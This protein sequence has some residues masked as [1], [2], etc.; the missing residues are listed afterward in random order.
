MTGK[1]LGRLLVGLLTLVLAVGFFNGAKSAPIVA[2]AA[3]VKGYGTPTQDP[4]S[5]LFWYSNTGF[6]TQP[7]DTYT[8]VGTTKKLT[9]AVGYSFLDTFFNPLAYDHFQ[10][11]QSMDAGATWTAIKG[12]TSSTLSVTPSK[13]G[14]TYYQESFGYYLFIPP[15]LP[16]EY[17]YS[18]VASVTAMGSPVNATGITVT[19]DN[20]YLYSNQSEAGTTT[21]HANLIP[22]NATS[23]VTWSSS[24]PGLATVD[25]TSGVV[26][27]NTSGR[28]G[29]AT[30]NGTVTN[31]DG[32]TQTNSTQIKVGGGLDDQTVDSGKSATFTVQGTFPSTPASVTW[33]KEAPGSSTPTK[34]ASGTSLTY[35]TPTTSAADDKAHYY[36]EITIKSDS[37]SKT[38]TT[39]AAELNV[40]FSDTPKVTITSTATDNTDNTGNVAHGLSNVISGDAITITG[41]ITDGNQDSKM[42]AG[43]L[44]IRVPPY[45]SNTAV[46]IDGEATSL[47]APKQIGDYYYLVPRTPV[48]F[49]AG[50]TH[51]YKVS[52]DSLEET[53]SDFTSLVEME[54]YETDASKLKAVVPADTILGTTNDNNFDTYTGPGISLHFSSNTLTAQAG[55]VTFGSLSYANV[56]QTIEGQ[57]EGGG[58]LLAVTDDRRE[59]NATTISL[60]Q[61]TPFT[62]GTHTLV[63]KLSY[64][65]GSTVKQLTDTNQ[66]VL[67]AGSGIKVGSLNANHGQELQLVLASQAIYPGNYTSTLDWTITSAP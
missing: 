45:C 52:F 21:V 8:T 29:T 55:N 24:D 3:T 62:D 56:D 9:T 30:I 58:D 12:A 59:K 42:K 10:W 39:N 66:V 54:A 19:A 31:A 25:K 6:R 67:S 26:T 65:N 40:K 5:F 57:V 36:A 44:A 47:Q 4:S 48:D 35:T 61:A 16:N 13:V 53:D 18:R 49:E 1:K 14:T 50:Q 60:R 27:A 41:T 17:Y 33:Y 38:I 15:L 28:S 2:Q 37:E 22:A 32:S 64:A 46:S 51:T 7:Q 11:Y 63:A 23:D 34:V 20:H 43:L